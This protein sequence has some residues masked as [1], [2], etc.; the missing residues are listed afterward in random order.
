MDI[1]DQLIMYAKF[2]DRFVWTWN[3]YFKEWQPCLEFGNAR[4]RENWWNLLDD[5]Q[6]ATLHDKPYQN[7]EQ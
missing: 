5:E 7:Q 1:E 4:Q 3:P 2:S 6:K